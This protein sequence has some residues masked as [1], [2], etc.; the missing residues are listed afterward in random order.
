MD[1]LRVIKEVAGPDF[2]CKLLLVLYFGQKKLKKIANSKKIK[3]LLVR[4][5]IFVYY[6]YGI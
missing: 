2:L 3:I 5:R 6:I 4:K 1:Q